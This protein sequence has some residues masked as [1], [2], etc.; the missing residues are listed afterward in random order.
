MMWRRSASDIDDHAGDLG[1][2]AS[3]AA[4]QTGLAVDV[5]DFD[6]RGLDH[7][8]TGGVAHAPY[9]ALARQEYN[10]ADV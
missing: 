9:V 1:E 2:R 7:G 10:A 8:W 4:T 5:A 3:A 6:A